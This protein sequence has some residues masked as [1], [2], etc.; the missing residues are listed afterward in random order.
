[1][2]ASAARRAQA[3]P[4]LVHLQAVCVALLA[5]H[6]SGGCRAAAQELLAAARDFPGVT[7]ALAVA[8]LDV[9]PLARQDTTDVEHTVQPGQPGLASEL[10]V[11]AGCTHCSCCQQAQKSVWSGGAGCGAS[12]CGLDT[13]AGAAPTPPPRAPP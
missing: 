3:A 7:D 13:A 5:C 2:R 9:R 11:S 4:R 10:S 12:T 8:A 1:M 6:G